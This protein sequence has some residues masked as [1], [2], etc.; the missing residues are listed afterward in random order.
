M[1]SI[2][3][4]LPIHGESVFLPFGCLDFPQKI[5]DIT[6]GFAWNS[7]AR[8]CVGVCTQQDILLVAA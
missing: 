3:S 6:L 2:G 1:I 8:H 4:E 5:E 7:E